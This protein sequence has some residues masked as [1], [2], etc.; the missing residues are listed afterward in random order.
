MKPSPQTLREVANWLL[1]QAGIGGGS[2]YVKLF[3][4]GDPNL[5]QSLIGRYHQSWPFPNEPAPPVPPPVSLS[6]DDTARQQMVAMFANGQ[7]KL[8]LLV[9]FRPAVYLTDVQRRRKEW[10]AGFQTIAYSP[11][12]FPADGTYPANVSLSPQQETNL[13]GFLA[14]LKQIGFTQVNFRFGG[15]TDCADKNWGGVWRQ[16]RYEHDRSY[17]FS[18]V[19]LVEQNKGDLN[20]IYDLGAEHANTRLEDNHSVDSNL[21]RQF[22]ASLWSDFC[23]EFGPQNAMA[24]SCITQL[25]QSRYGRV[26]VGLVYMLDLF[27]GEQLPLPGYYAVDTYDTPNVQ[28]SLPNPVYAVLVETYDFLKRNY[29]GEELKPFILQE[30]F[31]NDAD[32]A[33]Q[34]EQALSDRPDLQLQSV[35][36][37]P[38]VRG[39][40]AFPDVFPKSFDQYADL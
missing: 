16:D 25:N 2:N 12:P 31:Y 30:S 40:D 27:A 8:S 6:V 24:Y 37:W 35:F 10:V 26:P 18:I 15:V 22:C 7:R 23:N 20:A 5:L 11:G 33:R 28:P 3:D 39:S 34:I 38:R 32:V 13:V 29:P 17:I 4:D 9:H 19:R 21:H 36:Q 14:D 1:S